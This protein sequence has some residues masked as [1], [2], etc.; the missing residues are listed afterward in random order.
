MRYAISHVTSFDYD[1]PVRFARCNLRLRPID[2][3]GQHLESHELTID[4]PAA[5]TRDRPAG[6]PVTNTGITVARAASTLRIESRAQVVVER[7]APQPAA[8][9]PTVAEAARG[10]REAA[11][12]SALAPANYLF[13]SPLIAAFPE[14]A[15]WCAT[16]LRPERGVIE[17]GLAL[18]CAIKA[19][20]V[21]DGSATQLDTSPAEAFAKRHGVCQDFAQ[22]MISGA[23]SAG[24]AAAYVSGYIR[25]IPPPGKARLQGADATH[26]W[27]LIW[28]GPARGWI[29]FD[30]T[31]GIT[32][33]PDHIVTGIGR[34][35]AD[36]APIDGIFL[37]RDG[38][39]ID[40][41]V[42][43]E[44]LD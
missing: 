20:F 28:C 7:V 21:Y 44:P 23:R 1:F 32:M 2:F 25:T 8:D 36:V 30:P 26:A 24:L 27:V 12:L 31:N 40:V 16:E 35:Y 18:A 38:Q 4:P 3:D 10:A 14:I 13:P 22:I 17:A 29:G 6:Y 19:G 9:D 43:V 41:A 15:A 42:D 39:R 33:G 5:A 37:G 34:D 11:D